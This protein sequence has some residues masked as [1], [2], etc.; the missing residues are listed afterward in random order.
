MDITEKDYFKERLDQQ[1][2]WYDKKSQNHQKNY[3]WAKRIEFV[4]AALIPLLSGFSK[5]TSFISIS[6]GI[7]GAA[8]AVIEGLMSLSKHH[9]NWIEYRSICETLKQEKYTYLTRTGV[10]KTENPFALLVE[11]VENIISREN[12]NWANINS[13]KPEAKNS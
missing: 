2:E 4:L 7:L 5:D 9:E 10:Y 3:K 12:V 8:I 11:R 13:K 1:I 6:V